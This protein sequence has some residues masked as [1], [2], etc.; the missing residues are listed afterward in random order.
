MGQA[1]EWDSSYGA[2]AYNLDGR[3]EASSLQCPVSQA[4][5]FSPLILWRTYPVE[6]GIESIQNRGVLIGLG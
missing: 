4:L 6:V 5:S 2:D 1:V 3:M